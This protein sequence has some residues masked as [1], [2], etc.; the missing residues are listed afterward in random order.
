M[1]IQDEHSKQPLR[2]QS[3]ERA[4][5][6]ITLLCKSGTSLSVKDIA[7][8]LGIKRST[9][10]GIM[11]TLLNKGFVQKDINR[12]K[13]V[14]SVKL[15][16]LAQSYVN[17]VPIINRISKQWQQIGR[18][19]GFNINLGIYNGMNEVLLIRL[20]EKGMMEI[21]NSYT[22]I[23]MHAS[24]IGKCLLAYFPPEDTRRIIEATGMPA[25]TASTI[26]SFETLGKELE[27]IRQKGYAYDQAEFMD[28]T[29]CLAFP[30]FNSSGIVTACSINSTKEQIESQKELLI[31]TGLQESKN[32]SLQMGW[33]PN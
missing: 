15:F 17:K 4:L 27:Q 28:N 10:N 20:F 18:T 5:D 21:M 22:S 26:T 1:L 8:E 33:K 6:I 24:G 2:I 11:T 25:Y 16:V 12:G 32:G 7:D 29:Y 9:V 31:R 13:Y 19:L 3:V 23:P 30:I 14:E